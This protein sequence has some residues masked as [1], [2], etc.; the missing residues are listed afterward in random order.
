[1]HRKLII[2]ADDY[3]MAEPVNEAI[4][5]CLQAGALRSTCVMTNMPAYRAASQLR[6]RYPDISL[7]IHWT[8]TLGAPVLP[9]ERVTT[10]VGADGQ[11]LPARTFRRRLLAR[12]INLEQV[13]AELTAQYERFRD[14][15]G[16]P[17]YWNSHQNVHVTPGLFEAAVQLAG[18]LGIPLMRSH[19]R[20]TVPRSG[21]ATSYNVRHPLYWLRGKLIAR[22]SA[23][24]ERRGM[25]MPDGVVNTPGFGAG[26]ADVEEMMNRMQWHDV[27][28][29]AELVI[30][31]ATKIHADV[32][33]SLTESR[34]REYRAFRDPQLK[35]RLSQAGIETVGFEVL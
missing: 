15:A 1:M 35:L 4:E 33:G 21:S 25:R 28:R 7:G 3:G 34:L 11:L 32:F 26:K 19:R 18:Q 13:A 27:R 8:L 30:H 23:A 16:E 31:P 6:A 24:A 5:E 29:A 22:W 12:R 9:P 10:L 20:I 14:V 2:T 17:D